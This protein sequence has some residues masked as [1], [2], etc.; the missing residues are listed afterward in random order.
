MPIFPPREPSAPLQY[1]RGI[2]WRNKMLWTQQF[3]SL[4]LSL[5]LSPSLSGGSWLRCHFSLQDCHSEDLSDIYWLVPFVKELLVSSWCQQ[6]YTKIRCI[7]MHTDLGLSMIRILSQF[8][9]R[10]VFKMSLTVY[11]GSL[12]LVKSRMLERGAHSDR[13]YLWSQSFLGLFLFFFYQKDSLL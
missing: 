7:S 2:F 8:S 13:L 11:C 12:L 1:N 9:Y 5:S 4:S 3:L 6:H 10:N